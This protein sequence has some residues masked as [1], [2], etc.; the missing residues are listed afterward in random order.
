[1]PPF[2]PVTIHF[3]GLALFS[4]MVPNDCGLK[5][6]LPQVAYS[7]P[8]T[9]MS[10]SMQM[11]PAAPRP[12]PAPAPPQSGNLIAPGNLVPVPIGQV[13][14]VE[15]HV[16]LLVFP[17]AGYLPTSNWGTPTTLPGDSSYLYVKLNGERIR[18]ESGIPNQGLV[19]N[20]KLPP[21]QGYCPS[22]TSLN[23]RFQPPYDGAAAVFDL[24]QGNVGGCN[25]AGK[26]IDTEVALQ[27]SGFLTI[28]A[29]TTRVRK[30]IRL[31][32]VAGSLNLI[33]ANVP[34]SCLTPT[35]CAQ[36][37][38][39]A[40]NGV[41]HVHAYYEMGE[42]STASCMSVTDWISNHSALVA[43]NSCVMSSLPGAAGGI[44]LPDAKRNNGVLS[45][46]QG[47]NF[48]CSNSAWP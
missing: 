4:Q 18:F 5:V 22:L 8:R 42:G 27:S 15:D 25:Y 19:T 31:K 13:H 44:S 26:R 36:P 10:A 47:D 34:V 2:I 28:S 48:E 7:D 40:L 20:L 16:A 33:V 41:S 46:V 14:H 38:P 39:S 29:S 23:A 11:Q 43:H 24:P 30:E 32:P 3:V 35:G 9:P 17:A 1:M 21:L 45:A 12:A 37:N 6:I